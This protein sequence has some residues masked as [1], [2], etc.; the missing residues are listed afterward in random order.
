LKTIA[1]SFLVQ[2]DY[3]LAAALQHTVRCDWKTNQF[4]FFFYW[5]L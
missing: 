2:Y 3:Q 1:T 5:N 4:Q